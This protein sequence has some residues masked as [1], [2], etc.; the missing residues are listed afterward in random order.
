MKRRI[1]VAAG[2]CC[3]L[4]AGGLCAQQPATVAPKT[5]SEPA[6][7]AAPEHPA[8]EQQ[9][10]KYFEL[11]HLDKTMKDVMKQM[12]AGMRATSAPYYPDAFWDDMEKTFLNYDLMGQMV[13]IYQKHL[14]KEDMDAVLA[15]YQGPAGEHMLALQPVF[16]AETQ[17]KFQELGRQLGEQVAERHLDEIKAAEKNYEDRIKNTPTLPAK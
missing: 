16:A 8:T 7:A 11:I 12:L 15:F 1:A 3:V 9:I 10:H 4:V 17:S 13:P 6:T 5:V 2:L 14:S